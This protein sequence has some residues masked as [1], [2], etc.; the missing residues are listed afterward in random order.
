MGKQ[1]Q[2]GHEYPC[3]PHTGCGEKSSIFVHPGPWGGQDC[4]VCKRPLV[5]SYKTGFGAGRETFVAKFQ[6]R[7]YFAE[8]E[9][10]FS[11]LF[12]FEIPELFSDVPFGKLKEGS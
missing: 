1:P 8:E 4:F 3:S 7:R 5:I 2:P 12:L 9:S 6:L 11:T 10:L